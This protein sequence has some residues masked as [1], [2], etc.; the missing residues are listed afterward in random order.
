MDLITDLPSLDSHDSIMVIVDHGLMKGVI[1]TPCFKT[2]N[3]TDIAQIFLN[4]VFKHFGLHDT[5]I[6]GHGPQFAS[7]FGWKLAHL[8]K[9]NIWL[10]T[11]YHPQTDRQTEQT[12][13][14]LETYL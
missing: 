11:V 14:E 6:S 10:S 3:A 12:N 2:I 7:A 9:Y 1:L 4:N 8:L 5:L 13:P